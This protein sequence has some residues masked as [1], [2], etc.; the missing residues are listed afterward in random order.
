MV[1]K[2][3]HHKNVVVRFYIYILYALKGHEMLFVK[4]VSVPCCNAFTHDPR[5]NPQSF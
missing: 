2:H 1:G 5:R 4:N 3:C